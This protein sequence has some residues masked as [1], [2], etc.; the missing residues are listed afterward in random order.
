MSQDIYSSMRR[1]LLGE[2]GG[3][4]QPIITQP[5]ST[6][7][8]VNEQYVKFMRTIR[9]SGLEEDMRKI[10]KAFLAPRIG[11]FI[12]ATMDSP[13]MY[14]MFRAAFIL[15]HGITPEDACIRAGI[16]PVTCGQVLRTAYQNIL[17]ELKNEIKIKL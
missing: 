16:D 13:G 6:Q 9:S 5:I 1:L 12:N 15:R 17:S 14:E 3:E 4:V 8:A 11:E 7:P 10:A 2:G